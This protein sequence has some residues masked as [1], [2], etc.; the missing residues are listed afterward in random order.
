MYIPCNTNQFS[1]K[2]PKLHQ[3]MQS[4]HTHTHT[5]THTHKKKD[6]ISLAL[7]HATSHDIFVDGPHDQ[8]SHQRPTFDLG[9]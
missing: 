1:R 8:M 7:E 3:Q 4:L 9:L 2:A 5:H 6:A